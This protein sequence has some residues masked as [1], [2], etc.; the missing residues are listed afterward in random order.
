MRSLRATRVVWLPLAALALVATPAPA[1]DYPKLRAGQWDIVVDRS[2]TG[3]GPPT[4]RNTMC[5]D[6][7]V[8]RDM[9]ASGMGVSREICTRHDFRREG[10]RYIGVAECNLGESAMTSRSVMTL[11][12]D[13]AYTIDVVA[14]FN[15]PFM[16]MKESRTVISGKYTGP[17][18]GG[19]VPGDILG[20]N[21][22]KANIRNLGTAA[23]APRVPA[24]ASTPTAPA[25][26]VTP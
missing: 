4:M 8:Q 16:G 10:A 19:L 9:I 26:K 11:S 1:Q 15:P 18:R 12:G 13:T 23:A 17:C 24:P 3:N 21:G 14:S 22:Q 25:K 6:E 2:R 20:P 5:T 7:A